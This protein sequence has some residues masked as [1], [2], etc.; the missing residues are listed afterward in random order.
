[1][2]TSDYKYAT[3]VFCVVFVLLSSV[4]GEFLHN[5]L[6]VCLYFVVQ[7][8][9]EMCLLY[10]VGTPNPKGTFKP[11]LG[12]SDQ[13]TQRQQTPNTQKEIIIDMEKH[14]QCQLEFCSDSVSVVL[15]SLYI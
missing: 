6:A 10:F 15:M 7:T 14:K 1:M 2:I 12:P 8:F 11:N 4:S 13:S 9:C 5:C 3:L